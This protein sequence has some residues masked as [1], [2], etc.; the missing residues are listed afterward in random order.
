[1]M[2]DTVYCY[3]CGWKTHEGDDIVPK[4]GGL[5]WCPVCWNTYR[6]TVPMIR[7]TANVSPLLWKPIDLVR[8]TRVIRN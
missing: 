2:N 3:M 1:M 8:V 6:D 4:D 7:A 5:L